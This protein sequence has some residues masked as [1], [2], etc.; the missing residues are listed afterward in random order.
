MPGPWPWFTR[1]SHS[2]LQISFP[3]PGGA[4]GCLPLSE[5]PGLWGLDTGAFSPLPAR[6]GGALDHRAVSREGPVTVHV[7]TVHQ[8]GKR[9]FSGLYLPVMYS[10]RWEC[11]HIAVAISKIKFNTSP[12]S[13]YDLRD[14]RLRWASIRWGPGSLAGFDSPLSPPSLPH[15]PTRPHI[16]MV[17]R[18][19]DHSKVTCL[20][21]LH[22]FL[23]VR[24]LR[25]LKGREPSVLLW[26]PRLPSLPSLSSGWPRSCCTSPT[27]PASTHCDAALTSLAQWPMTP[28]ELGGKA[29]MQN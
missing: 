29:E 13:A 5:G 2:S 7:D 26:D 12:K 9:V 27:P 24:I 22:L 4:Q 3:G 16:P 25:D 6:A 17:T 15:S 14:N 18:G 1:R 19:R 11:W 8:G 21:G 10:Q 20:Q 23:G 28:R